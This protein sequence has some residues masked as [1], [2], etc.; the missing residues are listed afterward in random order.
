MSLTL[1]SLCV[2]A[3][4]GPGLPDDVFRF[5]ALQH[6]HAAT[7]FQQVQAT[8][9]G[10]ALRGGGDR[11]A[12]VRLLAGS[13]SRFFQDDR[14]PGG[15]STAPMVAV[16]WLISREQ[17]STAAELV[18]ATAVGSEVGC[19]V[20]FALGG[21]SISDV[22]GRASAAAAA[23]TGAWLAGMDGGGIAAAVARAVEAAPVLS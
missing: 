17:G 2:D 7:V 12:K 21:R 19:R 4:R 14:L 23:A 1:Q 3:R 11:E 18:E 20:G 16:G 10:Q 15:L 9:E 5:A 22:D 13:L 8:P 6:R